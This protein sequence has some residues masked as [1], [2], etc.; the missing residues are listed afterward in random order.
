MSDTVEIVEITDSSINPLSLELDDVTAALQN[1]TKT[2]RQLS[3][4][5]TELDDERSLKKMCTD[6]EDPVAPELLIT[7]ICRTK[8]APQICNILLFS[9]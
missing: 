6:I 2:K 5:D 3:L 8:S 4:S 9:F 1:A 7:V